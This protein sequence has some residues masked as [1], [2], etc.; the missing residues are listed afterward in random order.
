MYV[1]VDNLGKIKSNLGLQ[2]VDE[3]IKQVGAVLE[4]AFPN[5]T[6]SR[7]NGNNFAILQTG[8]AMEALLK[9]VDSVRQQV[10]EMLIEVGTR[11]VTTTLTVGMVAIDQNSPEMMV[12]ID[13]VIETA[14]QAFIDSKNEGNI[15]QFYDPS[16]Y[17]KEDE[18]AL[19]EYLQNALT[20]NQFKLM[21]QPIYDIETD[22]SNFFE[23]YL[24]LPLA[25]GSL[26]TP[27]QFF[28][29][30]K[31][32]DL[33]DKIDRWV[34]INA[35]KQLNMVRKDAPDTKVL[36]QLTSQSLANKKLSGMISQLIKALG[37]QPDALT[38]Q[39]N[40]QELV[41][42]MTLAKKQF[43]ALKNVGCRVG[44]HHFGSTAKTIGVL[45]FVEPSMVRLARNYVK[46]LGEV[47]NI[48]TVKTLISTANEHETAVLMPY[49]EDAAVMSAAWSVG[50]RYLQGYYLQEPAEHMTVVQ[51]S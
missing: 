3:T 33:M 42:H 14:K 12:L 17:A 51:G 44:I 39:F 30:A 38:V 9:H 37:G 35:C 24:R 31:R 47:T 25:D 45:E 29:V 16:Q 26:M 48:E 41:D 50:A 6:V 22:S 11:T 46:D 43:D 10:S 18:D 4:Q 40:E 21:Y 1:R 15:I 7:F 34:L 49:I 19:V 8:M 5:G 2:G 23:V 27:D 13:R 28:T 32:H 36:I 20:K